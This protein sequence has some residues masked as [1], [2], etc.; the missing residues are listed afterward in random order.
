MRASET[1]IIDRISKAGYTTDFPLDDPRVIETVLRP[2]CSP[3]DYYPTG[4]T[5]VTCR[6]N[7]DKLK[8]KVLYWPPQVAGD[9]CAPAN[10]SRTTLTPSPTIPGRPNTARYGDLVMTSPT[11]YYILSNVQMNTLAGKVYYNR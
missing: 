6:V 9:F 3:L 4:P 8:Y 10:V 11:M 2:P 1:S 5:P 7:E